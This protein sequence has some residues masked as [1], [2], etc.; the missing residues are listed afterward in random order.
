MVTIIT[1]QALSLLFVVPEHNLYVSALELFLC[2]DAKEGSGKLL[3]STNS[4]HRCLFMR[5]FCSSI[6]QPT[7][8]YATV[9]NATLHF[10]E[11]LLTAVCA[12]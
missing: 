9:L 2:S 7:L 10:K 5:K 4:M 1:W 8:I 6:K 11:S 12:Q 3:Q